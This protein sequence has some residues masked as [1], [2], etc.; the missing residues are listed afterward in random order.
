MVRAHVGSRGR[1]SPPPTMSGIR[2]APTVDQSCPLDVAGGDGNSLRIAA[3]CVAEYV[4]GLYST[5]GRTRRSA[6][7]LPPVT[8]RCRHWWTHG[9]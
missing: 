2:L 8:H 5:M 3:Y 4:N 9:S 7:P 1:A 6:A